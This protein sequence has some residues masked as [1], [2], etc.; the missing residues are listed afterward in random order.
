MEATPLFAQARAEIY[1][2]AKPRGK[3]QDMDMNEWSV[4]A[5]QLLSHAA[6]ETRKVTSHR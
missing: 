4:E 3:G 1:P 6:E 5:L 2:L